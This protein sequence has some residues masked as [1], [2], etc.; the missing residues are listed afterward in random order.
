MKKDNF[1]VLAELG[2]RGR[3]MALAGLLGVSSLGLM[4]CPNP[5]NIEEEATVTGISVSDEKIEYSVGDTFV[6]PTV[7][8][9]LD[10]GSTEDV[11]SYCTFS[12]Y[13]LS[14]A[15][16]YTVIVSYAG[17]STSYNI[18]VKI[19]MVNVKFTNDTSTY[20]GDVEVYNGTTC[21]G[22]LT[23]KNPSSTFSFEKGTQYSLIFK[24]EKETVD[25]E[26][27]ATFDEDLSY[28]LTI[29][30]KLNTSTSLYEYSLDFSIAK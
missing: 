17:I 22:T 13:D 4:G 11:T 20:S 14:R 2:P 16:S 3:A 19:Q 30:H 1:C 27:D 12:G 15:G 24:I 8:A 7:T 26:K 23:Q 5:N 21:L 6:K 18:E 29:S 28:K 25:F 9:T 10:S